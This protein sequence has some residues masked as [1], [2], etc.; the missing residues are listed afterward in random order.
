MVSLS[1]GAMSV[2]AAGSYYRQH[3]ST[4]GEYYAPDETPTIGQALGKGAAALGLQGD[5]TAAQFEAL[6]RG[7]DPVSGGVLRA[8]PTHGSEQR[9]GWDVTLSPPKSVS[10][11]ALV[12]GDTRLIEADRQAARRALE[13][14]EA[15]ALGRRHGGKQWVQT[16]NIVAVM[17]EHYDARESI[18]SQHGPM[19]QLH[20]H[21]FIT[22]L[23]Q[24]PD[25]HWRGLDPKEI[26]KARRF[27]DA[28]YLTELANRIQQIGYAIERRPDGAFE[29]AS[30]TR[31]QIEAFSER[32]QDIE[33]IKAERG[34]TNAKAAREVI[35]ETRRAKHQHD[36][37]LLRAEREALA[38][39][40]GIAL[41]YCPLTPARSFALSPE[42]QAE[43][44]LNFALAHLTS[45]N[46]VP[47][48]RDIVTAALRHGLGATDLDHLRAQM[49]A[50]QRAGNLVAGASD[51]CHPL[52]RYTT[53]HMARLE[54]ENLALI[55]DAMEHGRPLAGIVI[56]SAVDGKLATVSTEQVREWTAA[57]KLLPDQAEAAFLTLTTPQWAS[58]IEGLAGTTKTT[59]VGAVR[60]FAEDHGWT[61]LGFGTT[62]GQRQCS[63]GGWY[64]QPD[65]CQGA[66]LTAATQGRPRAMDC[67]RVEPA[68]DP[69]G[70]L[71]AQA[72]PG[73]RHRT[74]SLCRRPAAASCH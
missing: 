47:D 65:N 6:L 10:I 9:A 35:I 4:V 38:A 11:Q 19:P 64:R 56:R 16:R 22:N 50:Q 73:A 1:D 2:E 24:M 33:R 55:R 51:H 58:A 15:C 40:H 71:S 27:I 13:Q 30:Y 32:W 18:T 39:Q 54:A 25:G 72:R 60:E 42:E 53:H 14:A 74:H 23:T 12:A 5:I 63:A 68:G 8:A 61:V 21:T 44:S 26:Y 70:Q 37:E 52:G 20:H 3:Y 7:L 59:T 29:L 67:R 48:H 69:A 28:V 66:G 46:A 41:N 57:K 36:P 43:H 49:A 45:R 62:S 31:E 17:F 34:I